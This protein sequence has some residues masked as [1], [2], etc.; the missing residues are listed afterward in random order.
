MYLKKK[1]DIEVVNVIT[2]K[3]LLKYPH[4]EL[5]GEIIIKKYHG[6]CC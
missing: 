4:L 5:K 3:D 2:K 1:K 6:S